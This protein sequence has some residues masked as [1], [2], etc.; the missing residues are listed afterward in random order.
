MG[1]IF[2]LSLIFRVFNA[3]RLFLIQ[4]ILSNVTIDG[5]NL[6]TRWLQCGISP[7]VVY[8][9]VQRTL[10]SKRFSDDANM[11]GKQSTR[12]TEAAAADDSDGKAPAIYAGVF[13][14]ASLPVEWTHSHHTF[15]GERPS[16]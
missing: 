4:G 14:G 16:K 9:A 2:P 12:T 5:R 1:S 8:A 11:T 3:R 7:T 10:S 6:T 15:F 13:D